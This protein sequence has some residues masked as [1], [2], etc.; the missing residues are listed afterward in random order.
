MVLVRAVLQNYTGNFFP[1]ASSFIKLLKK[2]ILLSLLGESG[3]DLAKLYV[4]IRVRVKS[5]LIRDIDFR[6]G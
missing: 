2:Y 1:V 3:S 5:T 6:T 4:W